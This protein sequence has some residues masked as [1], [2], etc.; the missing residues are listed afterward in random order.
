MRSLLAQEALHRDPE[1]APEAA[2]GVPGHRIELFWTAACAMRAHASGGG[3]S[4][5]SRGIFIPRRPG[6]AVATSVTG[7]VAGEGEGD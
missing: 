3:R 6:R 5:D 7:H 4:P 1:A 2:P